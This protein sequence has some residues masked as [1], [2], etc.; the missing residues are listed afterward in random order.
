MI[1][2]NIQISFAYLYAFVQHAFDENT[3]VGIFGFDRGFLRCQY[4]VAF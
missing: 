2:V 1:L 4:S 3:S